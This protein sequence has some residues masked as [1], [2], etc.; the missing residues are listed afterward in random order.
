LQAELGS[1]F[2]EAINTFHHQVIVETHSEHL[3]LRIQGLIRK[4]ALMPDHV[5]IV[6][7][8]RGEG[9][10]SVQRLR[11]DRDGD[12]RDPWPRGFFP[13]RLAEL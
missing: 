3:M 1:L 10:S 12:F 6:Y 4:Q 8:T 9:G 7:V 5:C 2:E 11:L 13:E